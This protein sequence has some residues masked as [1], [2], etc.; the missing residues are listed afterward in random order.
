M[1]YVG[2]SGKT[3]VDLTILLTFYPESNTFAFV[4]CLSSFGFIR[5]SYCFFVLSRMFYITKS[6]N[7]LYNLQ[8]KEKHVKIEEIS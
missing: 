5:S 1:I 2:R 8:V 4:S 7:R 6:R 3:Y